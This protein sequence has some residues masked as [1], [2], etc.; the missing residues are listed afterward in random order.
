MNVCACYTIMSVIWSE[1]GLAGGMIEMVFNY[2]IL[3]ILKAFLFF[4]FLLIFHA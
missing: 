4:Y 2:F 3:F 1:V